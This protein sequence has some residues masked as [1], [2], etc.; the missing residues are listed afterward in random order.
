MWSLDVD[1]LTPGD[2]IA[3]PVMDGAGRV[4]LQRGMTLTRELIHAL[5]RHGVYCVT[6]VGDESLVDVELPE[7]ISPQTR[8][9]ATQGLVRACEHVREVLGEVREESLRTLND[10]MDSG[11]FNGRIDVAHLYRETS[12]GVRDLVAEVLEGDTLSGLASIKTYDNYL[13]NHSIDV[14]VTSV[15]L[16]KRLGLPKVYL[17]ELATGAVLHDI[18]KL[19][20]PQE[21]LAKPGSLT[22]EEFEKVKA[23]PRFGYELTRDGR[24]ILAPHVCLQHHEKQDGT[25]YPHGLVGTNVFELASEKGRIHALAEITSVCDIFDAVVSDRVYRPGWPVDRTLG[26]IQRLSG[27]HLNS[28]IVAV[29]QSLIPPHPMGTHVEVVAG[30]LRGFQGVVVDVPSRGFDRPTIRIIWQPD[31]QRVTPVDVVVDPEDESGWI[32]R[33]RAVEQSG[34]SDPDQ[35]SSDPTR[36]SGRSSALSA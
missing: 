7:D 2:I 23:H 26:L 6:V 36:I 14:A 34:P 3:R 25:G 31:G 20:I 4:L 18:G 17:H 28:E 29:F 19:L 12:A 8:G 33:L 9:R 15:M 24:H 13:F 32:C 1:Q 10:G 16:G 22:A 5:G 27:E 21:I 35:S 11:R 30:E